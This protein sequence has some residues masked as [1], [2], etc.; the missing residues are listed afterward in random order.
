MC[1]KIR[2]PFSLHADTCLMMTVANTVHT[3]NLL[4]IKYKA[5]AV[6]TVISNMVKYSTRKLF[7]IIYLSV[8]QCIH[9]NSNALHEMSKEPFYSGVLMCVFSA[10][11]CYNPD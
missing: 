5:N 4:H 11:Q 6:L 3:N 8:L 2:L 7:Q 1:K 10:S 9:A